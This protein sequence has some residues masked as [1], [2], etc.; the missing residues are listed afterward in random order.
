MSFVT[1]SGHY[2]PLTHSI[3]FYFISRTNKVRLS[4]E[5]SVEFIQ[6]GAL[7]QICCGTR[8]LHFLCTLT[9]KYQSICR[10]PWFCKHICWF[11]IYEFTDLVEV[12]HTHID[13]HACMWRTRSNWLGKMDL[14]YRQVKKWQFLITFRKHSNGW[15]TNNP[16]N[17]GE[18]NT[19]RCSMMTYNAIKESSF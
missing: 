4:R 10:T 19:S 7:I 15:K 8:T 16:N 13:K 18:I 1:F 5:H 2:Q 14:Y 6:A 12:N 9:S 3:F 11:L 17:F